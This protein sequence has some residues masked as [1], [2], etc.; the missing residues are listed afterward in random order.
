MRKPPIGPVS[1]LPAEVGHSRDTTSAVV[2]YSGML[3]EA[4]PLRTL[5]VAESPDILGGASWQVGGQY[6]VF[7]ITPYSVAFPYNPKLGGGD[8][9]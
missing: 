3:A 7:A 1:S 2:S 9:V 5:T 4:R 8:K 6:E